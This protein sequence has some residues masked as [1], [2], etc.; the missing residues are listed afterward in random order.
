MYKHYSF[1]LWGTLIKSNPQYKHA[2]AYF[3]WNKFNP[4][5]KDI[6]AVEGII[7]QVELMCDYSNE[8]TGRNIDAL[9]MV[10]MVLFGLGYDKKN[11]SLRDVIAIDHQMENLFTEYPPVP[12]SDETIPMLRQLKQH[13]CTFSILSN[14]AFIRGATI[15]RFLNHSEFAG[16][17]SFEL[18][19]DVVDISKPSEM[20][21]GHMVTCVH[22]VRK[23]HPIQHHE[24]VHVGD[25]PHADI[26]GA[27]KIGLSAIQINTNDKTIKHIG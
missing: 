12:Y 22:A 26:E 20:L 18:F 5:K 8:L 3:F 1:D 2:R 19:S 14:T 16:M 9:E 27:K 21:F 11:L 10:S 23:S 6:L 7:R 4:N 25:N 24:I 13:G 15:Q 17:F